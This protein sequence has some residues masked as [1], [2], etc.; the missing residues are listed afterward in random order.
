[1]CDL[2]IPVGPLA[3]TAICE[4]KAEI[5]FT[6]LLIFIFYPLVYGVFILYLKF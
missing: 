6:K 3:K 1:M 5:T 4:G 2:P